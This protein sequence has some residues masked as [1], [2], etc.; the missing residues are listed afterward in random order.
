MAVSFG[1]SNG[2]IQRRRRLVDYVHSSLGNVSL[3][4]FGEDFHDVV[5]FSEGY[6]SRIAAVCSDLSFFALDP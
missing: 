3:G 2:D 4:G 1:G 6:R 5:P